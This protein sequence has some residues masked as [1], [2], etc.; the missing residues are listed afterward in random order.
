MNENAFLFTKTNKIHFFY[1][2]ETSFAR[3]CQIEQAHLPRLS[4]AKF[5]RKMPALF[6]FVFSDTPPTEQRSYLE[7]EKF[8]KKT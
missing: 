4:L 7:F 8:K 3:S 2:I 5:Y 1:F 6:F